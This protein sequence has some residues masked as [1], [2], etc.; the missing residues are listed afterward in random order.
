MRIKQWIAHAMRPRSTKRPRAGQVVFPR[1]EDTIRDYPGSGLTPSRLM[2]LLREA[3]DGDL[4]APMQLFEEMEEKDAHLAAVAG[5]RRL[6]LTGLDW[7]VVS[8]AEMTDGVDHR[9]AGEAAEYCR[10]V[11]TGLEDFDVTL[12]HLAL[13]HG[14]NIAIAEIVWEI[15]AGGLRPV[16]IVPVDFTRII[17]DELDRP[18]ILTA[19]EPRNG[20]DL[21][22]N[23]FIVHCPH[24]VS[25][26]PQR[27][28]LLRVSAM[29]YLA[30]NMAL[31]DWMIFAE[32]FGMP[33]RVARYEPSATAEEKR[34]LV[35][36]LESLGT[37]AAG[38]FSRAVQLEILD[39]NR[40]RNISPHQE[41][42]EFINREISKAW[43][44]QTLTTDTFGQRGTFAAGRVH[45]RVRQDILADDLRKE[46]RTIR[47]DLLGP[48]TRLRFGADAP[49]PHFRRIAR[50]DF[51]RKETVEVADAAVNRLGLR[52]PLSWM[53]ESLRIPEAA[54]DERAVK[55]IG[56]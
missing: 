43:L 21:A 38:I 37:S 16:E 25:G 10:E 42:I 1:R 33:V 6:A 41:L 35:H 8:A 45:E 9:V 22:A 56:D 29:L 44:G 4:S 11:L 26:H 40:G 20:I 27:G 28:G 13:A 32:I 48:L 23:K 24:S 5:T 53:H 47:R 39:T 2:A 19:D 54:A 51:D 31:K 50:R 15:V 34:E 3:D 30:K 36:M 49:V 18:R 46:G 17:F 14:R 52:V 55:Q 12:Q 7:Q